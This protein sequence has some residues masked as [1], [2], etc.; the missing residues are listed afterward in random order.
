[1]RAA[2][3]VEL[4]VAD[5]RQARYS[6]S[7]A[8]DDETFK[9]LNVSIE[10]F[11][12]A[13][14]ARS[15]LIEREPVPDRPSWRLRWQKLMPVV[16]I[17]GLALFASMLYLGLREPVAPVEPVD[18]GAVDHAEPAAVIERTGAELVQTTD[19]HELV[20]LD[21]TRQ[22]T[23]A[24]GSPQVVDGVTS[25]GLEQTDR[26]GVVV[27][28]A[29]AAV[30]DAEPEVSVNEDIR[31]VVSDGLPVET[32]TAANTPRQRTYTIQ[33]ASVTSNASA[34]A[35]ADRL[36]DAGYASYVVEWRQGADPA[37]FRVRIGHY[38]DQQAAE[39]VGQRVDDEEGLDW[40]VVALP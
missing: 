17:A 33:V 12:R 36:A 35:L 24:D 20:A 21:A 19:G 2:R 39:A 29:D 15:P 4:S 27:T 30:E 31:R 18:T 14:G 7:V 40:Y 10:A 8:R 37:L 1:M 16:I 25:N 23:S 32:D 34:T 11:E 22:L 38:P 3:T 5:I 9:E 13:V 28:S 26:D 6:G